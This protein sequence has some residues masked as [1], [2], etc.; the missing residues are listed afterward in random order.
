V[1]AVLVAEHVR[2]L[3]DQVTGG[4]EFFAAG[5]D[6]GERGAVIVGELAGWVR[7]QL[8][9]FLA[10]GAGVVPGRRCPGGVGR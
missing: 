3:A 1:L 9:A 5:G 4:R 7:I 6:L 8:A 2:E 10:A